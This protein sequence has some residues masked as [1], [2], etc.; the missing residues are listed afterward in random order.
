MIYIGFA[1]SDLGLIYFCDRGH[2]GILT[3]LG[4]EGIR[5]IVKDTLLD[6]ICLHLFDRVVVLVEVC[7]ELAL[8]DM[9]YGF[10]SDLV[11]DRRMGDPRPREPV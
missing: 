6:T 4:F 9:K 5:T 8:P 11:N 10:A 3:F 2:V 1:F 7:L